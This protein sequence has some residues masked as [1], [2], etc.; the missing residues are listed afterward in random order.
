MDIAH[1]ARPVGLAEVPLPHWF[2]FAGW[3][4]DDVEISNG[5]CWD[6]GNLSRMCC[7][8]DGSCPV[9]LTRVRSNLV[10][11]FQHLEMNEWGSFGS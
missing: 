8:S 2:P 4:G 9:T 1:E 3:T 6:W 7:T 11:V 5:Q 10:L